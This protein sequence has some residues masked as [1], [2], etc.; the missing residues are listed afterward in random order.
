MN[1]PYL[2]KNKAF[3][4]LLEEYKKYGKLVIATDFDDT[5]YDYHKKDY[6]YESVISLLKRCRALDF[7][8]CV[9]TGTPKEKWDEIDSYMKE[10]GVEY[11]A[12]NKNAFPMC[13]GN[14]GKIYYNI[15]L[16]D[17]A[18]LDSAYEILEKVVD[19]A[20]KNSIN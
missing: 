2:N 10:I 4:R 18:G 12:I 8:I 20:E 7:Y 16:D 17:R 19:F 9:F 3:E 13:F 14:D 15:L 11:D 5:L 6:S 1:D